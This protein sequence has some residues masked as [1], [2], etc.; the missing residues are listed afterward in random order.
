M[1]KQLY[2]VDTSAFFFRAFYAIRELNTSEGLPTNAL[3]GL[4]SMTI[5]LINEKKPEYMVF[6]MDRKE[7]TFRK[8]LDE[9]YKANRTEM[10][11]D[12]QKQMPYI[13]KMIDV[14]GI[15][16]ISKERY[17]ADDVIG[18][19]S[20]WG[21]KKGFE[22]I[23]VSSDKDLA[24]LVT[25]DTIIYDPV[26]NKIFDE[27]EVVKKWGVKPK[28]FIDYLS[29][30]GDS[31]DNVPG[32]KGLG[33]KGAEKLL[34]EY[35]TLDGVYENLDALKGATLKKL[36]E[37]KDEAYLSKKLVTIVRDLDLIE[38]EEDIR[39]RGLHEEE[40]EELFETLEF[41]SF[42]KKLKKENS[43]AKEKVEV[44]L[45]EAHK[46]KVKKGEELFYFE[47]Q[48]NFFLVNAAGD[49]YKISLESAHL[50]SL[51]KILE[52]AEIQLKGFGLKPLLEKLNYTSL[53]VLEDTKLMAYSEASEDWSAEKAF[54]YFLDE[55]ASDDINAFFEM[56]KK[57]EQ[58]FKESLKGE[59]LEIYKGLEYP[60][61]NVLLKMEQR[62]ILLDTAKLEEHSQ[63]LADKI[64]KITEE[65]HAMV[66][67][68]FNLASPK[69]L[70][71]VL[72][73]DIGLKPIKKTKTGFSTNTDV[74]E[75]L[76]HAHPMAGKIIEFREVSKLKS[77]YVD[78]LPK[79]VNP[80]TKRI[81]TTYNQALTTTG[82]LSSINPNLQN[83]PIR[84]E[85]GRRVRQAFIPKKG[86][87]LLSADYSQIE[88]RILA[89]ITKDPGLVSAFTR[90]QDVHSRTA[91]EVF[92]V[93]INRVTPEQRRKAKAVNFGIA[94][95]QGAYGLSESLGIS[96]KEAKEIIEN[97]FEKFK[98]V[99]T[100]IDETI[101]EANKNF[102]TETL[103]GR[104]RELPELKS[105]NKMIQKFGER[106]AI[107]API[108][109]SAADLIKIA[110]IQVE[111]EV[112][113]DLLLQVHDE[114]I[115]EVPENKVE[116]ESQKIKEIM[117]SAYK[118]DVPLVVGIGYG[119]NWDEAH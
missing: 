60:L 49:F 48:S 113:S 90:N 41:T 16:R 1:K 118:L 4:L 88:L 18:S 12:L 58:H 106:A 102:F 51:V 86:H 119:K 115:F 35:Q 7:P 22:V 57:L 23:V 71:K 114:L 92:A 11:D 17:E 27:D 98:G 81:H 80:K 3:Y 32:V 33:P 38:S 19:L 117:E 75:K 6:C 20:A 44:P 65:V 42:L 116:E 63:E 61:Q 87:V 99:K 93:P 43:A 15:P 84:T 14:L 97:Y 104:K 76:K 69:Q 89:H 67:K 100:Y 103:I 36:Q 47:F 28:Q 54:K 45:L 108:Q 62:G 111:K 26:K 105:S 37:N 94:Y 46:I 21:E 34:G 85:E 74:L 109:G 107:N 70:A 2:L 91:A 30:V 96:R 68:P 53:K 79:L 52:G 31:S 9:R 64:K 59:S 24:Q 8:D 5:K 110:M 112:E 82:R 40:A 25:K 101:E 56:H 66:D 50:E 13:D 55:E 29:I 72:F 10:P 39:L 73:E 95:G 83:I 78:A 77:T